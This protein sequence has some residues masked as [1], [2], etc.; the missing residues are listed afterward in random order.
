[1]CVVGCNKIN[2]CMSKV[3]LA[4]SLLMNAC[5]PSGMH[6]KLLTS[7]L[8]SQMPHGGKALNPLSHAHSPSGIK[9]VEGMGQLE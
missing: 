6:L 7:D 4:D 3:L 8:T 9:Q 1:M 5:S 2:W